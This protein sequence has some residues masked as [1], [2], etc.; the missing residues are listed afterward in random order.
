MRAGSRLRVGGAG[1][2]VALVV[3]LSGC[4]SYESLLGSKPSPGAVAGSSSS[5]T[6]S[7]RFNNLLLGTPSTSVA[8][9]GGAPPPPELD[10]PTVEIRQGA[11]TFSQSAQESGSNVL[12]LRFQASFV[13][14][15]RECALRGGNVTMKVGVQGRVIVGP[16]GVSGPIAL[17]MR[18]AVVKEGL[19]P[20]TIWT[21]FYSVP[22]T[23]PPGQPN[24][25]FTQIEEDLT[26]PMPPSKDFD[27]YVI[28]VGFDPAG[29]EL[30]QKKKPVR[31]SA[32]PNRQ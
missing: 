12:S 21:R 27:Q 10:C 9:G 6:F 5:S 15:A 16:A 7:E 19:E 18:L 22:V 14:T 13:K 29:A 28:Y 25:L 2:A 11:S 4:S 8:E 24:V 20:K 30:E 23:M 32:K 3:L 31:P 17:P 26:V 1:A